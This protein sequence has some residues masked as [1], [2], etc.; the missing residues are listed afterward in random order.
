[1][2]GNDGLDIEDIDRIVVWSNPKE[3]IVLQG[4]ANKIGDGV[5]RGFA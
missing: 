5:L 1:M 2:K 4:Q 3:G